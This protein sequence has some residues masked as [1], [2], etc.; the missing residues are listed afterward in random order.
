MQLLDHMGNK[1]DIELPKD[2]FGMRMLKNEVLTK[3]SHR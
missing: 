1:G 2:F 3:L